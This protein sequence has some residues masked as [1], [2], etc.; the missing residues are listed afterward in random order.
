M[1]S[2]RKH[3]T[4]TSGFSKN[5]KELR[6]LLAVA[7][8]PKTLPSTKRLTKAE[9]A[10]P[11]LAQSLERCHLQSALSTL[12]AAHDGFVVAR[13][14]P[15][16]GEDTALEVAREA[17]ATDGGSLV[18]RDFLVVDF[19]IAYRY[20]EERRS[21]LSTV[22]NIASES[23]VPDIAQVLKGESAI[24]ATW[25]PHRLAQD[26]EEVMARLIDR[27]TKRA[28]AEAEAGLLHID[29]S[30]AAERLARGEKLSDYCRDTV[31]ECEEERKAS[32]FH[33]YFFEREEKLKQKALEAQ[34]SAKRLLGE[35]RKIFE[36]RAQVRLE[37]VALLGLPLY[38]FKGT[39]GEV[40][41]DG[42]RGKVV[43]EQS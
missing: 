25:R 22:W 16:I 36:A 2:S 37:G 33:L 17:G 35:E 1:K 39:A 24:R 34:A 26:M 6:S 23:E 31:R 4:N 28:T 12:V 43:D 40:L 18:V 11:F 27:A 10:H 30:L 29:E 9:R 3:K 41:V 7:G 8:C 13:C 32:Y 20:F 38:S 5:V 42:L 15:M 19:R 14:E 21:S